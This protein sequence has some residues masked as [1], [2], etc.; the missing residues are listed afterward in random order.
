[1]RVNCTAENQ[2]E[3]LFLT[4]QHSYFGVMHFENLE[5]SVFSKWNMLQERKL[6]QRFFFICLQPSVNKNS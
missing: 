1:M 4:R 5:V 3:R 6:V 2:D